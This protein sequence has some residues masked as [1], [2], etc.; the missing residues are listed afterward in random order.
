MK[1]ACLGDLA[2]EVHFTNSNENLHQKHSSFFINLIFAYCYRGACNMSSAI[3]LIG[4]LFNG[5]DDDLKRFVQYRIILLVRFTTKSTTT[6][7]KNAKD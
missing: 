5:D 1:I 7:A 6:A 4:S 3:R 2:N